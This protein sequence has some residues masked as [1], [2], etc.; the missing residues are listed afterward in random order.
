MVSD[1]DGIC[2]ADLSTL[3]AKNTLA[4]GYRQ[5]DVSAV[6]AKPDSSSRTGLG[7]RSA[8]AAICCYEIQSPARFGRSFLKGHFF[9]D[10]AG[11]QYF[12]QYFKHVYR[13]F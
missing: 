8:A 13:P 7:T 3:A 5:F 9:G 2:A 10:N 1:L 11:F 4:I 12:S 6:P